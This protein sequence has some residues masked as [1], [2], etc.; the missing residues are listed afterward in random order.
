MKTVKELL[1]EA[2]PLQHE[3]TLFSDE[4]ESR[5]QAVL[6]AASVSRAYVGAQSSPRIAVFAI[7][8]LALIVISSLSSRL[9]LPF[10]T[11][12][13]GAVRF[14]VRLA[15]EKRG[16]GL[17]EAQVSNSGRTVYLHSEV[18]VDNGDIATAR[19]VQGD[20]PSQYAV[21]LK[22]TKSGAEKMRKATGSH[23]GKPMA[24]LLD[25]R[26]VMAP[27]VRSPVGDSAVVTGRFTKVEAERIVNGIGIQ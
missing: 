10:V 11:D 8:A 16:S 4:R 23:I 25:G 19:V 12:V 13:K 2:D 15:E 1:Q 20:N 21:D 26:V 9:W 5:R 17:R 14:E 3:P 7:V 22:F 27:V 6:A 18:V 24:I